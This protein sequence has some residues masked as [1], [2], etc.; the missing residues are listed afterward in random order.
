MI[1]AI[2]F[3]QAEVAR[4]PDVA[5]QIAGRLRREHGVAVPLRS[6]L[7]DPLAL[8][9]RSCE[10][11]LVEPVTTSS[12]TA[13]VEELRAAEL[14]PPAKTRPAGKAGFW[15]RLFGKR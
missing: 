13:P 1:T 14:V 8:I 6:L 7:M 3:V 11:T 9:A 2:V 10:T 15:A 4:I 12:V 5:A